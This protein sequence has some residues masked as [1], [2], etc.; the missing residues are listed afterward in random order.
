MTTDQRIKLALCVAKGHCFHQ[1][2]PELFEDDAFIE[3][4]GSGLRISDEINALIAEGLSDEE[5]VTRLGGKA[6]SAMERYQ[7]RRN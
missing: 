2:R 1:N 4:I 3:G 6:A 7:S 5:I